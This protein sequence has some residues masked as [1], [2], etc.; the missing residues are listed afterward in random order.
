MTPTRIEPL[1]LDKIGHNMWSFFSRMDGMESR[2]GDIYKTK[3]EALADLDG[4][5]YRGGW[6]K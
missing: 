6:V 3:T 1:W 2:V 5:A 4:Y